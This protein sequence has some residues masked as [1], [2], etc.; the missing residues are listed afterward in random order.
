MTGVQTC[1]LPICEPWNIKNYGYDAW[2][3]DWDVT[4]EGLVLRKE[5]KPLPKGEDI[6]ELY[7][8][9]EKQNAEAMG[10]S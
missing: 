10:V 6:E 9:K 1:A 8:T 2:E 4:E 3:L 5:P 7:L